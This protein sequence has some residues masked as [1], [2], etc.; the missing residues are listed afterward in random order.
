MSVDVMLRRLSPTSV[1]ADVRIVGTSSA[2]EPVDRFN[3]TLLARQALARLEGQRS[4]SVDSKVLRAIPGDRL[5]LVTMNA[6][7]SNA[8]DEDDPR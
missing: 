1:E 2:S 6:C 5:F 4:S 7:E 8:D 3:A